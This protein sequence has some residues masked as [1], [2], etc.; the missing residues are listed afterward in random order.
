MAGQGA[1]HFP[2][3][4]LL[5]GAGKMGGAMLE[6]WLKLGLDPHRVNIIEPATDARMIAL[7]QDKGITLGA[8]AAPSQTLV[9]AIK[10]QMLEPALPGILPFVSQ[11]TLVISILAGKTLA[12]LETRFGGDKAIVRAMPNLPASIG[13]GMTGAVANK[14]VAPAQ[15]Q[16]ADAL[17]SAVG[18]VEWLTDEGLID[19][20][21]AISGCGP[22]YVFYL[23]ECLA[24]AGVEAGLPPDLAARLARATIEGAGQLLAQSPLPPDELR[25]N[26][27][28]PGGVT[29]VALDVLMAENSFLS[30]LKK[31]VL[32]AKRRSAE[33][34]G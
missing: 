17:L 20:L 22:A 30:L 28:S 6:G 2:A 27:T 5:I 19:A 12:D 16:M 33:L 14:A 7:C 32:A 15:R 3:S 8:P 9:L 11:T 21:T 10:P 1:E 4:L 24:E 25:R 18:A 31:A 34:A 13:Y 29:A 23:A 26:V